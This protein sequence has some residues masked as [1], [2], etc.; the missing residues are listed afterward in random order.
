MNGLSPMLEMV[1]LLGAVEETDIATI[2]ALGLRDL[3]VKPI[4]MTKIE[5][6]NPHLLALICKVLVVGNSAVET[7]LM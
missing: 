2:G 6:I 4:G 3:S 1:L 7:S 5:H